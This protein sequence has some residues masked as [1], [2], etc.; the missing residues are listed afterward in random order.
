MS[1]NNPATNKRS[2]FGNRRS[3]PINLPAMPVARLCCQKDCTLTNSLDTPEKRS[4]T[5]DAVNKS[6]TCWMPI[7]PMASVTVLRRV[8]NPQY[9]LLEKRSNRAVRSMSFSITSAIIPRLH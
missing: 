4:I 7:N 1:C 6:C 9:A 5:L 3:I 8:E 2:G